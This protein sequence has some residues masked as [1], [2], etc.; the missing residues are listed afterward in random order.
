MFLGIDLGTSEIKA[1]SIDDSHRVIGRASRPLRVLRPR[2][3]LP[4]SL[5]VVGGGARSA[6][7]CRL[8][9]CVLDQPLL[10]VDSAQASAALGAARLGWLASGGNVADVCRAAVATADY[11]PD[12]RETEVLAPRG[13]RYRSLYPLLRSAFRIGRRGSTAP[14]M[15]ESDLMTS[16]PHRPS[17]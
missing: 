17:S 13:E 15:P 14:P 7:W 9:A 5:A 10:A 1:L 2:A 11:E 8:L 4:R 6:A 16:I 3:A 12:P